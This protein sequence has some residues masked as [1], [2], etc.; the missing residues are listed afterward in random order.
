MRRPI[1]QVEPL[2]QAVVAGFSQAARVSACRMADDKAGVVRMATVG[3]AIQTGG[4]L[5]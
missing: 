1:D 4:G 5:L 3:G 2:H